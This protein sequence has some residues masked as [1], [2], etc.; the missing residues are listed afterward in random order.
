MR[1]P[2]TDYRTFRLSRLGEPAFS[3][4]KLLL[5]WPIYFTLYFLTENLIPVEACHVIHCTLDDVIPFCEYFVVFYVLWY[6]L[7]VG[8]L[9]YYL[10]YDIPQFKRLQ[11]YIMLTQ[12]IAMAFYIL[13][14]SRQELRPDV[15]QHDNVFTHIM[16]FIYAFDTNTG[17]FP[18]LHVGY[19]LAILSTTWKDSG[20]RPGIK[21]LNLFL[22]LMVAVSV[23]FVKQH[24]VLDV[25]SAVVMCIAIE[26]LL[27]CGKI[28][29]MHSKGEKRR[30]CK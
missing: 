14:P 20:L 26:I 23:C 6:G 9:L 12:V 10:L 28:Y 24:S 7:V 22:T 18:S 2:A 11:I 8:W 3:H 17:V 15:F 29:A 1:M 5:G 27:Y 4:L 25:L 30:H 16:T 21:A 19:S 13:Y